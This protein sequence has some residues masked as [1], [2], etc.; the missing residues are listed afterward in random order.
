MAS[1]PR[2]YASDAAVGKHSGPFLAYPGRG[3]SSRSGPQPP[4]TSPR[5]LTVL[6]PPI[7]FHGVVLVCALV[8]L[9][10]THAQAQVPAAIHRLYSPTSGTDTFLVDDQKAERQYPLNN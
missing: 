2:T 1:V 3:R 10:S 9:L 5:R 7:R 6:A 8:A 4:I